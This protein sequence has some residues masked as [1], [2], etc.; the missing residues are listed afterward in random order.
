MPIER[1]QVEHIARLARLELPDATVER[2][3][4]QLDSILDYV[5]ILDRLDLEGVEPTAHAGAGDAPL[6]EDVPAPGLSQQEALASGPDT[7]AGHFRVPRV[8]SDR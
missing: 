6:R 2:L 5:A 3:R 4:V 7:E 8:L 1:T